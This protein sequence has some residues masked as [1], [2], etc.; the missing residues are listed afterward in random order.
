MIS[1]AVKYF[2]SRHSAL[3]FLITCALSSP[4]Y[5]DPAHQKRLIIID[6]QTGA[7]YQ[8]VRESMLT[9]L[10]KKGYTKE[11]GF[12]SEYYSLS[13]Y[14]GAAKSLWQ[15]RMT[16]IHYDAIFLNGTLAVSSFKDIAWQ[17]P[18]YNFIYASVTDP[19]GLG[20]VDTYDNPPTGN[21]TGIAFHV[22]VDIRM[23]FVKKLIPGV[24]NIGFVY[25]DMPQSHSYR[26]WIENL[27]KTP[28]WQG[29]NFHFRKVGF[30]PSDGGHHRMAQIAKKH[31]KELDPIVDVFLSPNDQMGAQS[32]FA[33]NVSEIATKPL[34]GLGH[35]D[36]SLG[37]GATASIY[38][39]EIAIGVQAANMIERIFQGEKISQIH[40]VRPAS[41]GIVVDKTKAET[42]G[43]KLSTEFMSEAEI[44]E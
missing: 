40:P 9:E 20:L 39:D 13:H 4:L 29:V 11:N 42:F 36:V 10:T 32:P 21:F 43:I 6:S 27:Q 23:D 18:Q 38:P 22:P 8:T 25:A 2:Y 41:Y 33:K 14:H 37:W 17:N 7:P 30:I 28:E 16:K 1:K 31:I 5:S 3:I 35:D 15:H 26:Q 34:I 44:V 12:I 19:L 24:K